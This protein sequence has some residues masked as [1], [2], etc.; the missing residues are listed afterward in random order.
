VPRILFILTGSVACCKACDALSQLV[1]RGHEVRTV[2]TAAALRFV[3]T[4]TL[5]AITRQPVATDLFAAGEALAHITLVR[6]AEVVVLCPATANTLNATAAGLADDLAG[7]LLLAHDWQK[8]LLVFPAMNPAM[9][10]HPATVASVAKLAGWGARIVS[11][12]AGRTACGENGE[13]RLVEPD[14]IVAAIE[15]ALAPAAA[16]SPRPGA[17]EPVVIPAPALSRG[18]G[19][20]LVTSGGTSEPIDGVRVLSNSSTGATGAAIAR[21]FAELGCEVTL[22]RAASAVPVEHPRVRERTFVRSSELG[23]LLRQELGRVDC[24]VV[25][26]AAAVSDFVVNTIEVDGCAWFPGEG[27]IP[28]GADPVLKL[29]RAPKLLESLRAQ[30]RNPDVRVVAFKLTRGAAAPE[31]HEAVTRLVAGGSADF[32]VHNDLAQ[33]TPG[34]AFPATIYDRNAAVVAECAD[35]GEI[36]RRLAEVLS[37]AAGPRRTA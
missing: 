2:A 12:A 17:A 5:E 28:S 16:A 15:A 1:Q 3:G 18:G 10:Q 30:S 22:L 11:P 19:R 13:G 24:S 31:I 14:E 27:K 26:H 33:R 9:W 7:S 36:P 4:P 21:H 37:A 8:P 29:R 6:W 34:G 35:R 25:I 32:V 20:V 23:E